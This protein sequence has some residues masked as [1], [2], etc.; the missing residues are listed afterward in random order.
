MSYTYT[1]T[2][3]PFTTQFLGIDRI[4]DELE[5][6]SA[7]APTKSY[8]P[9]TIAKLSENIYEVS[10]A[11]AGFQESELSVIVQ[12]NILSISGKKET[13]ASEPVEYL[14]RG[15]SYKSFDKQIKLVETVEVLTAK[16][17]YGILTILL[18]NKLPF[19]KLP[20]T[21]PINT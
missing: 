3:L 18:E 9:H 10:L 21:I 15:I 12:D 20:K 2:T 6:V 7:Q 19:N 4:L 8:P 16:L 11:V 14:H 5:K 13:F 17:E 1:T